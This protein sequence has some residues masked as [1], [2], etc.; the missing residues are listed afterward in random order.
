[1]SLSWWIGLAIAP[2]LGTRLLAVAPAASLLP[3]TGLAVAAGIA[4]L[5]L[6][7]SIP[8]AISRT[9]R[10]ALARSGPRATAPRLQLT[11]LPARTNRP[12]T[13]SIL[14]RR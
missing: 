8:A 9:P 13:S 10:P 12:P 2:T 4:A 1:M 14:H 5:A 7:R 6:G 3:A 11:H